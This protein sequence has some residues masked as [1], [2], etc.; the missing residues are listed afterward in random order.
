MVLRRLVTAL[1]FVE[2]FGG[3]P[4]LI[5]GQ[6]IEGRPASPIGERSAQSL[7]NRLRQVSR[8]WVQRKLQTDKG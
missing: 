2:R 1:A 8:L 6:P 4:T 5:L 3:G 7:G